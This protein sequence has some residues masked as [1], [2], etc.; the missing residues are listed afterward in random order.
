MRAGLALGTL[1][2]LGSAVCAAPAPPLERRKLPVFKNR[3]VT[4]RPAIHN[5]VTD[6][7]GAQYNLTDI[8]DV[9]T[10]NA[11]YP[12]VWAGLSIDEAAG[13]VNFLHNHTDLNLTAAA[14]AGSW[15]N[16]ITNLDLAAP[17]KT[18][19]FRCR[20]E[21]AFPRRLRRNTLRS[22]GSDGVQG[23]HVRRASAHGSGHDHVQ[24]LRR[25]VP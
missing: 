23:W 1:I 21:P 2:A 16:V 7:S 4:S 5:Y 6:V 11:P 15:D 8:P 17:N 19:S 18:V 24:R 14:D 20:W 9:P 3:F 10:V 25:A 13:V 22:T 12:N